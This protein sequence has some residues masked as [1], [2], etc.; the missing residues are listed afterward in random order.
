MT[1]TDVQPPRLSLPVAVLAGGRGT[2]L[3]AR[4][5]EVP[6]PLVEVAGEPFLF[7]SL[8]RLAVSGV[9]HVVLC[10]GYLGEQ[11]E[12]VVGSR[13]FGIQVDYSYD[14]P[15]LDGTL[16]ALRRAQP[17]LGEKFLVLYG[18][19][20]LTLDYRELTE[21]WDRSALPA[22][23][24]VLENG[25]RWGP[26]NTQV[27][28]GLVVA[29]DKVV[30]TPEMTWIDYGVGGLSAATLELV[31]PSE[32]DL[33]AVYGALASAGQL[34]AFVVTQRFYEIGTPSALAE[35]EAHLAQGI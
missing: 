17:L 21:A 3:G 18:D 19:T 27:G 28:D 33:S 20:I 8:R 12:E 5:D 26:S 13:R 7:H 32:S 34:G 35:T 10:V 31:A 4:V 14:G 29:H 16:G 6:K 24:A 1:T 11:I 9:S 15:G 22:V 30:P 2:R 23:M 25:G